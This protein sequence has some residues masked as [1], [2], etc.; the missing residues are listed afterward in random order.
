ML[1]I[2]F[3]LIEL[4][5]YLPLNLIHTTIVLTLQ[6]SPFVV[7]VGI[8]TEEALFC[9][10]ED[11]TDLAEAELQGL[12]Y[13]ITVFYV[14]LDGGLLVYALVFLED[15]TVDFFVVILVFGFQAV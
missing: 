8:V 5:L 10:F 13:A 3:I 1:D 6:L 14:L 9:G 7:V 4:L 2:K 11:L 15:Q 12:D